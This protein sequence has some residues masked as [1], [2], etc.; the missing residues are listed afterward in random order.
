MLGNGNQVQ[1]EGEVTG[2]KKDEDIPDAPMLLA[3][4]ASEDAALEAEL[5][6]TPAEGDCEAML[7]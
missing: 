2:T 4:E 5:A 7:L 1:R 3:R 6:P